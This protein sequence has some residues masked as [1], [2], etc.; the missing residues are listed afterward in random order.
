MPTM[1]KIAIALIVLGLLLCAIGIA[2]GFLSRW[3]KKPRRASVEFLGS[4][5]QTEIRRLPS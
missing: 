3:W 1:M 4:G 5:D 2:T